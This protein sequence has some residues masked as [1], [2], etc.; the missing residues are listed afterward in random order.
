[1][2]PPDANRNAWKTGWRSAAAID[3]RKEVAALL[4]AAR[5]AM[6]EE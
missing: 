1:M 4:R 3:R 6:R 2:G 5:A